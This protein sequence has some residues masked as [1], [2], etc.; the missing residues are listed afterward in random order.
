MNSNYEIVNTELSDIHF[1]YSLFEDSIAYIKTN[2]YVG[3]T[4][5]D[6]IFIRQDIE[7][8]LQFKIVQDSSIL[9]VFSIC[10]TDTL[11][12]RDKE[13]GDAVYLHRIAVN[14]EFKGQKQFGKILHWSKELAQKKGLKRIRMDT[15]AANSNIINYYKS[16]GFQHIENYTTPNTN[17]LPEQHRN[18]KVA[19]LELALES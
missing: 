2:N 10:F 17:A 18:L 6:T 16:F 9:C 7:N 19:L 14:R 4:T 15:W 12:W 11:I 3:W 8:N 1:I 13:A 5:Y